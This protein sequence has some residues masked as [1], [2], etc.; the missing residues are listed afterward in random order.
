MP[1]KRILLIN[2]DFNPEVDGIQ[3]GSRSTAAR[4][5]PLQIGFLPLGLATVAALTPD[6]IEVDIWDE[7]V[8]ET[9]SE[10]TAFEKT[11]D[12]VGVTGYGN[13]AGRVIELG[14]IFRRRGVL[15]AVGGPGV[16]AEPERF[17]DHLDI[18]FLGEAEYTWPRFVAEW[19]A[20]RHRTEYRQVGKVDMAHS[21]VPRWDRVATGS[22]LAGSYLVGTV[23]T[24]RGCPFDCEFCDVIYIFG[25][26]A[27][28]KSV[29]QVLEE[30]RRLERLGVQRIYFCDDNFI[31][32]RKYAKDL[33]RALIPLNRSFR[34]PVAFHA[35]LTLNVARDDE[36][37]GLMAETPFPGI[38][39]GIESP[40]VKSLIEMNKPQNYR[41]D[42]VADIKKIHSFGIVVR[43]GMIVGFDHD[44]TTIFDAQFEFLQESG[45]PVPML[46]ILKA[47]TGT[48]L[49][50]RLHRGKRVLDVDEMRQATNV[51]CQTNIIPK[52]MT[53][54]E[55]FS[56]YGDL[57]ERV[58]DWENFE[59]RIKQL[60]S[61][62]QHRPGVKRHL[63][64]KELALFGR[65]LGEMDWAARRTTLRLLYYTLWQVPFMT[66]RVMG[67][68][69]H[70]Y[71]ETLR[72]P[73]LKEKLDEQIRR[74]TSGAS[75]LEREKTVFSV[76]QGFQQP[77]RKLFPE[78][79]DRV[80]RGLTDKSRTQ[81]ALV[82]VTY[83][84]LTRWGVTFHR[85]EDHHRG[86]LHE[87]CDR[88]VAAENG[89]FRAETDRQAAAE[90]HDGDRSAS[91]GLRST[92][93]LKRL[94]D[95]VL[96]CV[97]QDL[98]TFATPSPSSSPSALAS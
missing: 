71:Q 16:S 10:H 65:L 22:Y 33:V 55:L 18:L 29:D 28:H 88:A 68:V 94:A 75:Q 32:N 78:L 3:S 30:V 8:V 86:F 15:T 14:E 26:Q 20:G 64:W 5:S 44:D 54:V 45:I 59:L 1:V 34:R 46:N 19:S 98:R 85:F 87:I 92:L 72:V 43:G 57:V 49:W 58:R 80:Y 79:Y 70:Q 24:T 66:A 96:R 7:G 23:Q 4:F 74:L 37:L 27:R 47:P 60:L 48:K 35:Q 2:P 69:A 73:Y 36:M 76:P 51:E 41:T 52:Q 50:T 97:E 95:D 90:E 42:I 25:R 91:G 17:R 67:A 12:L 39:I 61:Q 40:N 13:H 77:Y 21:P 6:D 82:E 38:F 63:N 84:F 81:N 89:K 93:W 83:D 11:Y 9:I 31:G 53:L 56:G 62:V